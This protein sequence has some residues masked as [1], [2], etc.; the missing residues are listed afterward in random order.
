MIRT[1]DLRLSVRRG[2]AERA[3]DPPHELADFAETEAAVRVG[4][5][6]TTLIS[7]GLDIRIRTR[8]TGEFLAIAGDWFIAA[9]RL[10]RLAERRRAG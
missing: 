7:P 8:W 6:Q 3:G 2:L 10:R 1:D 5:A 4:A 9:E